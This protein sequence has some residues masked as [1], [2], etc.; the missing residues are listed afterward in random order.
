MSALNDGG[1]A[2]A[3]LGWE[4]ISK[5]KVQHEVQPVAA[6]TVIVTAATSYPETLLLWLKVKIDD[7]TERVGGSPRIAV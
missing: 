5:V 2:W 7:V 4:H 1:R 3:Q 6:R